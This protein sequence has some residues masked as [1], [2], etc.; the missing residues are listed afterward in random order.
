MYMTKLVPFSVR[1]IW[2]GR[3][4]IENY[5]IKTDLENCAEAWMLSCFDGF[6]STVADGEY[7]GL[8]NFDSKGRENST[9]IAMS[10]EKTLNTLYLDPGEDGNVRIVFATAVPSASYSQTRALI[11]TLRL[12]YV[13]SEP[14][15]YQT[16]NHT[17][18]ETVYVGEQV[19]FSA[20]AVV[21]PVTLSL[22]VEAPCVLK[23]ERPA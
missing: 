2:G 3:K 9:T 18:P 23:E 14:V 1:T 17:I 6:E 13:G 22:S 12:D 10:T 21:P 19:K 15:T 7:A 11:K 16:I 8:Y 4:L 20:N 5:G